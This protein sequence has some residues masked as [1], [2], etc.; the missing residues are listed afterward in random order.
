MPSTE[1]RDVVAALT[2]RLRAGE[3][4]QPSVFWDR[5][6]AGFR[7]ALAE[8]ADVDQLVALLGYGFSRGSVAGTI[9]DARRLVKRAKQTSEGLR[10]L[11]AEAGKHAWEHMRAVAF[12]ERQ[13]VLKEY[14]AAIDQLGVGSS[15]SV[16]AHWW[17]ARRFAELAPP[18]PLDVL[19]IGAGAANLAIFLRLAGRVR[20]YTI[21]DLPEMLLAAAATLTEYA[22]DASVALGAEPDATFRLIEQNE[23][24]SLPPRSF[25]LLCN[26]NSFMEMDAEQVAGYFELIYRCARPGALFVNVNRRQSALPLADGSTWDSNPLL[27]PYRADD[28]V[29]VWEDDRFQMTTRGGLFNRSS[30]AVFRAARVA[31]HF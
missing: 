24:G 26:V 11:R 6:L 4:G 15:F 27:Y 2:A 23:A 21:V 13:G 3:S 20:S 7:E 5:Q 17:Y 14:A 22:H 25:D 19:E 9:V 1:A 16:A 12:L 10:H 30:L 29:F 28:E 18:G 31:A 8:G